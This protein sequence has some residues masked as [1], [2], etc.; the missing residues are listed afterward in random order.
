MTEVEG[1]ADARRRVD[2]D[3]DAVVLDDRIVVAAELD[4]QLAALLQAAN[5]EVAL[6][7]VLDDMGAAPE[8][9]AAATPRPMSVDDVED[10]D[11]ADDRVGL[12]TFGT[13]LLYAQLIGF[14]YWVAS[15]IVEEKSSRV[16]EILLA[17]ARPRPLL[18]GKVLGIG[19]VGMAQL[20]LFLVVGLGVAAS[21][22]VAKPPPGTAGVA[23]AL[24][25]VVRG[26]L[27][28]LRLAVRGGRGHRQPV[29]R[30]CRARPPR[31][32]SS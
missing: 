19:I 30:S 25:G 26:R 9:R 28:P 7:A 17:K 1:E 24:V 22:E 5:R 11:A 6:A 3:L 14:G 18:A 20:V 13:T 23:V 32:R 4:P 2:D 31:S 21:T 16:I 29:A 10:S 15:G 12:A 27:R 8:Q